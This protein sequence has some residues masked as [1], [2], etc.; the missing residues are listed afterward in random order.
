MKSIWI[1]LKFV[2]GVATIVICVAIIV[3]ATFVVIPAMEKIN[4]KPGKEIQHEHA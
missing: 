1:A 4:K 3:I 2:Y